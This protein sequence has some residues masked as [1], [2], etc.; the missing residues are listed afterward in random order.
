VRPPVS[1]WGQRLFYRAKSLQ[2]AGTDFLAQWYRT[3]A[4]S[5]MEVYHNYRE[6]PFHYDPRVL[7]VK[8]GDK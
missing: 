7:I 6:E 4:G 2:G 5:A 1:S 8:D 3:P